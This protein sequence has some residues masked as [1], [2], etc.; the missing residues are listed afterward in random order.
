MR[1]A[2]INLFSRGKL[3]F[4]HYII[5]YT[6]KLFALRELTR[7]MQGEKQRLRHCWRK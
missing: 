5:N 4:L 6:A 2:L 1:I 7:R 3:Y